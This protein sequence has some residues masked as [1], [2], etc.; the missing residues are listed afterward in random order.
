MT[1]GQR[2][3][4]FYLKRAFVHSP[5]HHRSG[6]SCLLTATFFPVK[7]ENYTQLTRILFPVVHIF[8]R[9][10]WPN[11]VV[12]LPNFFLAKNPILPS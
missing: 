4:P 11:L 5:L 7:H 6:L 3:G 9:P 8:L 1:F 2:L 10:Q 12:F